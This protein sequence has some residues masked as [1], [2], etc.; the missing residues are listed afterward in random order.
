MIVLSVILMSAGCGKIRLITAGVTIHQ[1]PNQPRCGA[2]C[3][4]GTAPQW[5]DRHGE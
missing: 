1:V 4:P 2:V 5:N 3:E